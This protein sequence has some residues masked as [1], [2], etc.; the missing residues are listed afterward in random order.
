MDSAYTV[1]LLVIEAE[2]VGVYSAGGCCR[3]CHG[4]S[5]TVSADGRW[6]VVGGCF[7]GWLA[8]RRRLQPLEDVPAVCV[9]AWGHEVVAGRC[10]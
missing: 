2:V 4:R 9:D 1:G 10:R 8:F 7:G 3:G 5:F 6:L